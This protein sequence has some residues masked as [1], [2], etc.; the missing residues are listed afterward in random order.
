MLKTFILFLIRFQKIIKL[1]NIH[2]FIASSNCIET[3]SKSKISFNYLAN[4]MRFNCRISFAHP[5][6]KPYKNTWWEWKKN[7]FVTFGNCSLMQKKNIRVVNQ[8][9][10]TLYKYWVNLNWIS[11]NFGANLAKTCSF[12]I[13]LVFRSFW[14]NLKNVKCSR[15]FFDFTTV[16]LLVI[17]RTGRK[18]FT[19]VACIG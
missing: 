13:I 18:Q 15:N 2:N 3:I 5:L 7:Q 11:C 19:E 12:R 6:Q 17:E 1:I 9:S 8:E 4:R 10:K 14:K 16:L